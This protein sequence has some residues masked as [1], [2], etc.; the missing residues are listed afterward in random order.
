MILNI[1]LNIVFLF[2]KITFFFKKNVYDIGEYCSVPLLSSFM[3]QYI[4]YNINSTGDLQSVSLL[5]IKLQVW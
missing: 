3:D 5:F 1:Y 4:E 2:E